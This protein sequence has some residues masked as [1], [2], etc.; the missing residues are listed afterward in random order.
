M[1]YYDSDGK[2]SLSNY[3][4]NCGDITSSIFSRVTASST[5]LPLEH[6]VIYNL[7][8][9]GYLLGILLYLDITLG[10]LKVSHFPEK[11]RSENINS[12]MILYKSKFISA[13]INE[14]VFEAVG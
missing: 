8:K 13:V 11:T 4:F 12:Q 7:L 5:T 3:H 1:A 2:S 9:L 14:V 6:I 10:R